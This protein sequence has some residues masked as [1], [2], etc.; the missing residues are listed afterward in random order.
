M[1]ATVQAATR[2]IIDTDV[3][4]DDMTAMLL[5]MAALPAVMEVVLLTAVWGNVNVE[6]GLKNIISM[7]HILSLEMDWR[8]K[9]GLPLGFEA[10]RSFKPLVSLGSGHALGKPVVI[11]KDG[12]REFSIPKYLLC[13]KKSNLTY[14]LQDGPDGLQNFYKLHPDLAP[15]DSWKSLFEDDVPS[16]KERPEYFNYFNASR[17]PAHKEIIRVLKENPPNTITVFA[18][19]PMTNI[20]LAAAEDPEALLRMKELLVMGGAIDSPGNM[21]PVA[22][23]NTFYDPVACARSF[24]LSSRDP[25]S[26]MPPANY[27]KIPLGPYPEKL[28]KQLTVKLFPLDITLTNCVDYDRFSKSIKPKLDAGSPLV[29]LVNTYLTGLYKKN[30]SDPCVV[31]HDPLPMWYALTENNTAWNLSSPRDIRVETEG[32][33]TYG[34]D[35][36]DRRG[37]KRANGVNETEVDDDT[38]G[39]LSAVRGNRIIQA[40]ESPGADAFYE[41]V[42]KLLGL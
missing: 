15:D 26:T 37:E 3:G 8:K 34:M 32:Q 10:F 39:W 2:V 25:A 38:L 9:Q 23:F 33:W 5:A 35:V 11:E 29:T 24:A 41:R 17:L 19:G 31:L 7:F 4:G 1:N 12:F 30:T 27:C 42:M 40:M 14:M 13:W 20:A 22:E 28:S 18:L 6:K 21:S 36:V 16:P